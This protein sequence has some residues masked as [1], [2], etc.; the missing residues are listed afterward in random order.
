MLLMKSLRMIWTVAQK[1]TKIKQQNN[2]AY[3]LR[4]Q[5]LF[6]VV[7][8]ESCNLYI[9]LWIMNES[10]CESVCEW[11]TIV[12]SVSFLLWCFKI[13]C[14]HYYWSVFI[15]LIF[16]RL[17]SNDRSKRS[18]SIMITNTLR[19]FQQL[20]FTFNNLGIW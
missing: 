10:V 6:S 5:Q 18:A 2:E 1:K 19:H 7:K 14:G 17:A 11:V 4:M 13:S 8:M 3:Q 20:M 12:D 15:M 16:Q 9:A